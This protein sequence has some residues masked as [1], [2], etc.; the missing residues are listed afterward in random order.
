MKDKISEK[1]KFYG[2]PNYMGI[3]DEIYRYS[4]EL[5]FERKIPLD[6]CCNKKPTEMFRS[7]HEYFIKCKVCGKMTKMFRHMYEAKQAW[8]RKEYKE[9]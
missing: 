4:I 9:R 8:N 6:K 7:C 1:Y 2:K 3:T 5:D